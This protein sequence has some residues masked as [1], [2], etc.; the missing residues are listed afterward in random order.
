MSLLSEAK[1]KLNREMQSGSY[2]KYAAAMKTAVKDALIDLC[3]QS[4]S[5]ARHVVEGGSFEECMKKVAKGVKNSHISDLAAFDIAV[6][7]YYPKAKVSYSIIIEE[8]DSKATKPA[9]P[10]PALSDEFFETNPNREILD[11]GAFL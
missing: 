11:L 9:A 2:D 10:P 3:V 8:T 5:F 4:E 1:D 6:K 7:H